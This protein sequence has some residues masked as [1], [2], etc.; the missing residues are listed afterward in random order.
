MA[1]NRYSIPKVLHEF[2]GKQA[3]L[4][5]LL[6][7]YGAGTIA[8]GTVLFLLPTTTELWHQILLAV[9]ALDI[10]GGVVANF[11]QSTT[12]YHWHRPRLRLLFIVPFHL[13][14]PVLLMM[15]FPNL[16]FP[17]ACNG[18]YI[19]A[20]ALG[21]N[22]I[23]G[24]KE[25]RIVAPLLLVGALALNAVSFSEGGVAS[26]LL[27]LFGFKLIVAYAVRWR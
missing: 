7:T 3:T 4:Y 10:G 9:L 25:Q 27:T 1:Q 15:V 6:A 18:M 23:A 26:L 22:G 5:D 11:T 12:R 21:I 16:T 14:H 13:I 8:A 17:I 24:Y 2:H 20:A 19:I